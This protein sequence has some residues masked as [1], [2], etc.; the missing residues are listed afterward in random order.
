[1]DVGRGCENTIRVSILSDCS[2]NIERMF[3]SVKTGEKNEHP[4]IPGT[5]GDVD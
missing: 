3:N 5:S 4:K 1:M 2:I